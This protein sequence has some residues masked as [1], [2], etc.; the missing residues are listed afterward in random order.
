MM[1]VPIDLSM[2]DRVRASSRL[3][4][5]ASFLARSSR[6]RLICERS[7]PRR[8]MLTARRRRVLRMFLT[9]DLMR[10]TTRPPRA[11]PFPEAQGPQP[12]AGEPG[13][14][15]FRIDAHDVLQLNDRVRG[16]VHFEK[17]EPFLQVGGRGLVAAGVLRQQTII[18]RRRFRVLLLTEIDLADQ[19]LRVVR[20]IVR[21]FEPDEIV[22]LL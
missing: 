15:G 18:R 10:A 16:P 20:Q 13:L 21:G 11:L 6:S 7:R 17:R 4:P 12:L 3:A 5:P 2:S 1:P 9:A 22:Q 19:V 14:L 8:T